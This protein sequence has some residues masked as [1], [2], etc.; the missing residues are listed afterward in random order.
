M[1]IHDLA[2]AYRSKTDEELLQL[3]MD[4]GQ[5]TVE[6]HAA[7]TGELAARRIDF[8]EYLR[9]RGDSLPIGQRTC[10]AP[11]FRDSHT[12]GDFVTEVVRLYHRQF[13]LFF[14]LTVPA[15]LLGYIAVVTVRNEVRGIL[16]HLPQGIEALGHHAQILEIWLANLAAGLISWIAFCFSFGAICSALRQI[17]AGTFPSVPDSFTAI[18]ARMGAFLRLALLLFSLF[19]VAEAASVLLSSSVFWVLH[20]WRLPLSNVTIQFVV[21]ACMG[22]ALL[23]L[24]RFGLAI[25]ALILGDCRVGQAIFRSD[26]LT[27]GKWLTLAALVSK[28]LIGGYVAGMCPFWLAAYIPHDILLPTWFPW[29]LVVAS[30]LGVTVMEPTMFIGFA[31]LY[32]RTSRLPSTSSALARQLA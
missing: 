1:Q 15:V 16:R 14:K 22:S 7:L 29:I 2:S 13:W 11:F 5:L 20:R 9:T 30:I 17:E 28:S 6:A 27:E 24:S 18:R 3:A 8:N 23:V 4:S 19:L 31:L 21:L 25:P 32:S 12:V 26:T 10:S